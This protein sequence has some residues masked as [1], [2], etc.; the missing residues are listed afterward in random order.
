MMIEPLG[1]RVLVRRDKAESKSK[2]G[3][4]LPDNAK[5]KPQTGIVE[6]VGP[7]SEVEGIGWVKPEVKVGDRVLFSF[8]SG[9]DLPAEVNKEGD[10]VVLKSEELLGLI[11]K[12]AE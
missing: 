12:G 4:L 7:G 10:L 5:Q 2:G 9:S 1:N 8:Y 3:I 6:A 11:R